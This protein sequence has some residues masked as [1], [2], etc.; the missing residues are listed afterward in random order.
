MFSTNKKTVGPFVSLP[1]KKRRY[2]TSKCVIDAISR[3]VLN[4][5]CISI[6][7]LICHMFHHRSLEQHP[8]S[9]CLLPH[10]GPSPITLF[11]LTLL[12]NLFTAP[13]FLHHRIPVLFLGVIFN[14]LISST[15]KFTILQLR[16]DRCVITKKKT[17]TYRYS[18]K[19]NNKMI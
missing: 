8:T 7:I 16:S 3:P 14:S 18:H 15:P 17:V 19:L 5:A 10:P 1:W 11:F 12:N 13:F 2:L 9:H 4:T 6:Q